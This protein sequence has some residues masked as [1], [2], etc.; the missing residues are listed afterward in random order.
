MSVSWSVGAMFNTASTSAC[1]LS[2]FLSSPAI[3]ASRSEPRAKFPRAMNRTKHL[4]GSPSVADLMQAADLNARSSCRA[5]PE[6]LKT[7]RVVVFDKDAFRTENRRM[8]AGSGINH[9]AL[10]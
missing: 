6:H 1:S 2:T 5:G 8:A 4:A 9:H 3:G 10:F 7:F